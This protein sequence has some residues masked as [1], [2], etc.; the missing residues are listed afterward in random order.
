MKHTLLLILVFQINFIFAQNYTS[1]LTGNTTDAVT[2]P[3]G[4]VCLMGGA[5]EH[6][7]AMR[8]FLQQANGGDIVVIRTSGADGYNNYMY[9]QLGVTINSV[10]TIVFDNPLAANE[11]Y[12]QDKIAKAEAIWMAGGNQ[13][14][15]ISYWRNTAIDSIMRTGIQNRKV[16]IGGTSAGMAVLGGTYFTAQ[17]G[18]INSVTALSNPFN[19]NATIDTSRFFNAP[20]LKNVITDTHYNNPDR[21]GRHVVFL[22]KMLMDFGIEAKGI[23][24][25][26]YTSVCIDTNGIARAYGAYPS[27]NDQVYFLQVNC[28]NMNPN[29]ENYTSGQALDWNLGG[30]AVKVYRILADN[31]GT[32]HFD[33]NDWKEGNG[34]V[35]EDW[36]VVNGTLTENSGNPINCIPV[37]TSNL[38][39]YEVTI[40]PNPVTNGVL[41]IQAEKVIQNIEIYHINGQL[42]R[43]FRSLHSNVTLD[44]SDLNSGMY[45]VKIDGN[46]WKIVVH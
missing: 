19:S 40:T 13:W 38:L 44:V 37:N 28:E 26:E 42:I 30:N 34:G 46:V 7:N 41:N 39:K 17:N 23:A 21:K 14:N 18:T 25:D 3:Q 24:C 5:S 33:I 9:S 45:L 8:W 11:P 12:V 22:A 16:V 27:F 1:Y 31:N 4:G 6:D 35:W 29:P 2:S 36:Y 15:Y 32:K 20:F 10:E 43:T